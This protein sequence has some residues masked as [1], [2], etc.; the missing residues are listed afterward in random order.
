ML[1]EGVG[2][3]LRRLAK[4]LLLVLDI[5]GLVKLQPDA[6][7]SFEEGHALGMVSRDGKLQRG[8]FWAAPLWR[9]VGAGLDQQVY[10]V[11]V[12]I[13]SGQHERSVASL[14]HEWT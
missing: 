9:R 6:H 14:Y 1:P 11:V 3:K 13:T 10:D 12:T 2:V 4:L 7:C 8:S 5:A